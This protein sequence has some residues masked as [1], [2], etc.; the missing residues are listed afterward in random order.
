[1]T[2][3]AEILTSSIVA[4]GDFNPMIFSPDWLETN[5]LIGE[6]DAIVA[7]EGTEQ[8]RPLVSHQVTNFE[9]DWFTLQVLENQFVLS[10]RGVLSPAFRDLAVGILQLVP[11]TPINAIGLNFIGHFKFDDIDAYHKIG[12]EFAPKSVWSELYPDQMI[13]LEQLTIRVQQG[14]REEGVASNDEKRITLQKS[15]KFNIGVALS[16]N[17]HHDVTVGEEGFT[18]AERAAKV[19]DEQWTVAWDDAIRVF[20][21]AL[22]AALSEKD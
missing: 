19:A 18:T 2:F 16:Y 3:A 10:S 4:V 14:T 1:V 13:G 15:S 7:R 17:D 8:H 21:Q 12:D 5:G 20:D 22:T 6:G 9:V 11:H